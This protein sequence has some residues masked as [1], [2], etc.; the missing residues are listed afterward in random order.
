MSD[1]AIYEDY[2]AIKDMAQDHWNLISGL[3]E[4]EGDKAAYL[5]RTAFEHGYKHGKELR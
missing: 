3:L 4:V 2:N 5:Y 1:K